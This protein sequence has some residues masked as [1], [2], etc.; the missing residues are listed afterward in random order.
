[1][2]AGFVTLE[3][4]VCVVAAGPTQLGP[5]ARLAAEGERI[6][7]VGYSHGPS[8]NRPFFRGRSVEDPTLNPYQGENYINVNP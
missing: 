5:V 3:Q 4:P 2:V 6:L 7:K 8:N 1:M